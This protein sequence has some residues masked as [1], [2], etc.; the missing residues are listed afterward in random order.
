MGVSRRLKDKENPEW[1]AI[2]WNT[3]SIDILSELSPT[4]GA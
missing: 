1:L 3:P 4:R 2:K